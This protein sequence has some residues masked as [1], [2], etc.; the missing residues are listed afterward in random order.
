MSEVDQNIEALGKLGLDFD[1]SF[2]IKSHEYLNASA[3]DRDFHSSDE[4]VK[5]IEIALPGTR[6]LFC[7]EDHFLKPRRYLNSIV[8]SSDVR[9]GHE[10]HQD[11]DC[12]LNLLLQDLIGCF[13]P[14]FRQ[15]I[16]AKGYGVLVVLGVVSP[17]RL[18]Y[19]VKKEKPLL[20]CCIYQND[21]EWL[22]WACGNQIGSLMVDF[23]RNNVVFRA[24]K[25]VRLRADLESLLFDELLG[26]IG[27]ALLVANVAVDNVK[28]LVDSFGPSILNGLRSKTGGPC[29]D[30]FMMM[31]HTGMNFENKNISFYGE[32]SSSTI[33]P[34]VLIGSGPS[35]DQSLSELQRIQDQCIL[36]AAGSSI[37]SLLNAGIRPH[38]HVLLERG[39]QGQ[40]R[41][42][43]RD[44]L[45][46]FNLKDFG[47]I[48]GVVPTS[49]DP[50]LPELYRRTLMYARTGQSPVIAWP[51]LKKA[52]LRY[53]GPECLSA[54]FSFAIHLNPEA[55]L[56]FGCDLGSVARSFSR[57]E[58]A[59]GHSNRDF[60]LRVPG[61]LTPVVFSSSQM[62]LQASYMN[63]AYSTCAVIPRILNLSDGIRLSFAQP[64][65][66]DDLELLLRANPE[67]DESLG[68]LLKLITS[69]LARV[70]ASTLDQQVLS[71]GRQWI[72]KWI[73]L[74]YRANSS[75]STFL[76]LEAS[77]LLAERNCRQFELI[78]R[79]FR[80]TLR[81][82]F[83]LTSFAV[84]NIC[85][86]ND[87]RANCWSSFSRF[88]Q[89]IV[90]ELDSISSWFD[91]GEH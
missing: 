64:A 34:V 32:S 85:I 27:S 62:L 10:Y 3:F 68:S 37:G 1:D 24:R 57:S 58:A 14:D 44:L 88:L 67:T 78:F 7:S 52:S 30:E 31:S 43:Y 79:L 46:Q 86:N 63:A 2:R 6:K 20:I 13:D 35:L 33:K 18:A 26:F 56:M 77:R 4:H 28:H 21:D 19:L 73:D 83:W 89:S 15:H 90:L 51:F 91:S 17:E 45:N 59:V 76:R 22:P 42:V 60:A 87:D 61:N 49:I 36:V 47:E 66:I 38:F 40:V 5:C 41:D 23:G 75:P 12:H 65:S 69:D 70:N 55:V 81:D 80:G 16:S 29:I 48:V 54:A 50:Q 53:E 72:G 74:A 8:R 84:E 82:G 25:S 39:Y 11:P 71:A 9:I